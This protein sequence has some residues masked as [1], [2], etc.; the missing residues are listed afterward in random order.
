MNHLIH[1]VQTFYPFDGR[2]A[3]RGMVKTLSQ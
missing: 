2:T 3:L 1:I